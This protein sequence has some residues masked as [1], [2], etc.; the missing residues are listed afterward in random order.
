MFALQKLCTK[1]F[2]FNLNNSKSV[3]IKKNTPIVIPL[4]AFHNDPAYFEKPQ[5]FKPERFI[6]ANKET[7]TKCTFLPF[8]EGPRACIGYFLYT[9]TV[10][11]FSTNSFVGLRFGILQIKVGIAHII[12][13]F[14]ISLN[15]KTKLPLKIDPCYILTSPIGGFWLDFENI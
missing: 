10:S 13:N 2:T 3:T 11:F 14:A 12:K 1:D 4:E 9:I 5:L 15:K 7:I 8:G 6:G